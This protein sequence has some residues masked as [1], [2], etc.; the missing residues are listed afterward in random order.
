[1]TDDAED[2]P[3]AAGRVG[4]AGQGSR[5]ASDFPETAF[6]DIGGAQLPPQPAGEL[7]EVAQLRQVLLQGSYELGVERLPVALKA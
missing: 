5:A 7:I 4:E 6:N 3:I 1:M 2:D